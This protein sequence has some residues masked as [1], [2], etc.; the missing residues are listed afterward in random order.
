MELATLFALIKGK[1]ADLGTAADDG[2]DHFV[3]YGRHGLGVAL[4][5][6]GAEGLEDLIDCGH[7][8]TPPS[9]G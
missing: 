4:E 9:P 7:G 8:P 5:V 6:F 3:V 2:I 1:A